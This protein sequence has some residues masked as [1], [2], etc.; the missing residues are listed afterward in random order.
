VL[1]PA[2][3]L[4]AHEQETDTTQR[5]VSAPRVTTAVVTEHRAEDGQAWRNILTTDTP[6]QGLPR[7]E[8][9]RT[10]FVSENAFPLTSSFREP[11]PERVREL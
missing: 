5:R 3:G 8:F 6:H 9:D 10:A 7:Y 1:E 2:A 4:D 11:T